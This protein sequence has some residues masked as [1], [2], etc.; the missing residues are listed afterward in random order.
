MRTGKANQPAAE[1]I[2]RGERDAPPLFST[3][4]CANRTVPPAFRAS[5]A[6][7]HGEKQRK[8]HRR[9]RQKIKSQ[10]LGE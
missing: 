1:V 7:Q 4:G 9:S 3:A 2:E 6:G 10:I 8:T 5:I